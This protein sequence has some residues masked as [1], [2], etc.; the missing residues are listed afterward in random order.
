MAWP[1]AA[2]VRRRPGVLLVDVF[3]SGVGGG[4]YYTQK[5]Q[6][7]EH[8]KGAP[9]WSPILLIMSMTVAMTPTTAIIIVTGT[10]AFIDAASK[11]VKSPTFSAKM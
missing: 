10:S 4:G 1:C 11:E 8:P 3:Y 9:S 2:L 6:L 7:E 5:D